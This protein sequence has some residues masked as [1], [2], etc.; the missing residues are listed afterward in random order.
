MRAAYQLRLN[1]PRLYACYGIRRPPTKLDT[2]AQI[3]DPSAKSRFPSH[4]LFQPSPFTAL[5]IGLPLLHRHA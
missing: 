5:E 3:F 2:L 4:R 1:P